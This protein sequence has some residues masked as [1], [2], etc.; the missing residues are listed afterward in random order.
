[1]LRLLRLRGDGKNAECIMKFPNTT[2]AV[3]HAHVIEQ[4]GSTSLF[5]IQEGTDGYTWS[6]EGFLGWFA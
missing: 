1:M 3:L 6:I 5:V 4:R 2:L